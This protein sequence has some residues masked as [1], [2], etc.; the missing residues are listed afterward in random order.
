MLPAPGQGALAVTVRADAG[1]AIAAVRAAV[2]HEP[3]AV[4]VSAERGF[5]RRLEGGCQVPVA[6]HATL[7]SAGFLR[8]HGRVISLGGERMV[9]GRTEGMTR[10]S[11]DAEIMGS[12]LAERLLEQGADAILAEVRGGAAPAVP[13]P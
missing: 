12:S 11:E 4:A 10:T 1:E 6:A 5:L 3:S 7:D 2:H 8:L 13:E 9:E